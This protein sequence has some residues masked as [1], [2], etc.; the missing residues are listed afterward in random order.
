MQK[1]TAQQLLEARHPGKNIREII[2]DVMRERQ[3]QKLLVS[4]AAVDMDISDATLYQWC[5]DLGIAIEGYRKPKD[6]PGRKKREQV[7]NP[8]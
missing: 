6:E 3:G 4:R 2:E 5:R 8:A 7:A 1:T